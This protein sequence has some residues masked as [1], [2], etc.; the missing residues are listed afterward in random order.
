MPPGEAIDGKV[1]LQRVLAD[2]GVAARRA[3][4]ALIESGRVSVNGQT[5]RRLPVFVDPNADRIVV[6]GRPIPRPE[7]RVYVMLHKPAGT[8]VTA[9]DEPGFDRRT[10]LDLVDHPAAPRLFPVGRLDF[11]STGLVLLTNDGD[12]ANRLTHPRYGVPKTYHVLVRGDLDEA[13]VE[14]I[15]T[16]FRVAARRGDDQ[17][18]RRPGPPASR[19]PAPEVT[20]LR[21]SEGKTVLQITLR[22]ARN[23]QLRDLLQYMGMPVKKL[24]RVA[25]GP[26]QLRGLALGAWRELT[27]S[28]IQA[29]R[30]PNQPARPAGQRPKKTPGRAGP[31][32]PVHTP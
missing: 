16:K 9:A 5:V 3:C 8:V 22:E 14:A 26:L 10:V 7:R 23:R 12:L 27:R 11:D 30:R 31:P 18:P 13:A 6:D 25:I 2:A 24:A 4:E 32:R 17:A 19:G 21:R 15:R 29:L 20:I 28:E 1:R